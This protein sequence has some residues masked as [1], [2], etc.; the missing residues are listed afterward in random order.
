MADQLIVKLGAD[1]SE[2]K[3]KIDQAG[4]DVANSLGRES[5]DS[6]GGKFIEAFTHRFTNSKHL[7]GALST[8]LGL[9][10]EKMGEN[11]ARWITGV[12]KEEE[13]HLKK[14]GDLSE[15]AA[16]AT[17]AAARASLTEE[18]KYQLA[19]REREGAMK[20]IAEIDG[21]TAKGQVEIK[22]QE[23]RLAE[24]SLIISQHEL[25]IHKQINKEMTDR[26]TVNE[27]DRKSRV[28]ALPLLAQRIEKQ[29]EDVKLAKAAADIS[30]D[31][32][33]KTQWQN[34]AKERQVELDRML[35]EFKKS[36][37]LSEGEVVEFLN[38]QA[39]ILTGKMLP[40]DKA[41]YEQLKLITKEKE[42]QGKIDTILAVPAA[43]RT[44]QEKLDLATLLDQNKTLDKQIAIK[45]ALIDKTKAQIVEEK[46]AAEVIN[47][48][49]DLGVLKISSGF[50]TYNDPNQQRA[51]EQQLLSSA[52]R[53][54]ENEIANLQAKVD[55]YTKSGSTMG[56]YEIPALRSR[57]QALLGRENHL[58]D[59]VF[60]PNYSDAA[61]KGIFAQQVSTI[62]DPLKLQTQANDTLKQVATGVNALNERL[63][64]AGFGTGG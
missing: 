24:N 28:D 21:S 14:L 34:V 63:R 15:R 11:L 46:K 2:F 42:N 9:N 20:R 41:R 12:S 52:R 19:L 30:D 40:A 36:H 26:I 62:G 48:A 38:I 10:F 27:Q 35:A 49:G 51:Y 57:I 32:T 50:Q 23:I 56:A 37:S 61:G 7:A 8:A 54:I 43:E 3:G 44:K 17:I 39:R 58:Q 1:T 13:E 33:I 16:D 31:I 29:K 47:A 53:D 59:F 25:E 64:M 22:E 60:N 55:Q 18:K 45:Q 4:K 5:G 6:A